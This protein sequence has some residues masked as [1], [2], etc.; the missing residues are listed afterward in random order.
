MTP[1][2]V[3]VNSGYGAL[4]LSHSILILPNPLPYASISPDSKKALAILG[5]CGYE[6]WFFVYISSSSISS[7]HFPW[8]NTII[9]SS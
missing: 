2:G 5:L 7:G 9:L 4:Y 1:L 3:I 8:L 6:E